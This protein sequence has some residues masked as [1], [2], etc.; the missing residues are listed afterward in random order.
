MMGLVIIEHQPPRPIETQPDDT[1]IFLAGPIQ[2][3]QNWQAKAVDYINRT[4]TDDLHL[5][6]P[7]RDYLEGTFDY[8][9]QTS[10]EDT[11]RWRAARRG[12]VV[13]WLAAQD[14]SLPYEDG[15]AYGQTT[16]FE[17]GEATGWL[18]YHRST[19]IILGIE[20]G[21]AG[22]ERYYRH[23]AKR[24]QLPVYSTLEET[25]DQAVFISRLDTA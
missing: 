6:N 24:F 18:K 22:S 14:F 2:G 16:R 15:R 19:R 21:Y 5:A 1:L 3:A 17:F 10:W 12:A 25:L 8:E 20:P 13:F 11:G 7:R 23:Q 9:Q 4:V